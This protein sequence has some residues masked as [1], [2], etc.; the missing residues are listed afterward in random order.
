M[1]LILQTY[2]IYT[3]FTNMT[4]QIK[5]K[6]IMPEKKLI[7]FNNRGKAFLGAPSGGRCFGAVV[8]F[9]HNQ[10]VKK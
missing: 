6:K 9:S 1:V 7:K 8:N 3:E 2:L 10:V 4:S 5:M